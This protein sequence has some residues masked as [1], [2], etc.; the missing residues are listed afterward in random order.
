MNLIL[1]APLTSN[2]TGETDPIRYYTRPGIGWLYRR[3][4][5]MGLE[6]LPEFRPGSSGLEIGYGAG[7]V[8][9]NLAGK[10][11]DLHGLDLDADPVMVQARLA[12][13][14]VQAKL[15]RGSMLDMREFYEDQCFD[16]VACFSTMEHIADYP[17]ALNEIHRVLKPG[18]LALIGMPAVNRFMEYAFQAIG[19]KG[20]EDHHI[21][22]PGSVWGVI[23]QDSRKWRHARR[24]MPG[25]VPFEAALYHTFL[26][27]KL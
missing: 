9:C 2:S 12:A 16:L 23:K 25:G 5:E 21:T 18:G 4:I 17:G 7:I 20:I 27:Q 26:I 1:P 15:V 14:G 3:R 19:F 24:S 22:T 11:D 6:M 13:L 8:L 10:I